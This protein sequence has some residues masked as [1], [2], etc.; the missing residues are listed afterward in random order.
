MHDIRIIMTLLTASVTACASPDD[1]RMAQVQVSNASL[2]KSVKKCSFSNPAAC[3]NVGLMMEERGEDTDA[4]TYY[5]KAC[6]F[7]HAE[8]CKSAFMLTA[9]LDQDLTATGSV[10][11]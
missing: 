4:L 11:P 1:Q 9:Q 8:G 7:D 5:Q 3:F 10:K 2:V 6:S